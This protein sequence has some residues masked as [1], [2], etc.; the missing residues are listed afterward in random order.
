MYRSLGISKKTFE[1]RINLLNHV[2]SLKDHARS[3]LG[4]RLK[5]TASIGGIQSDVKNYM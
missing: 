3:L 1:V 5:F 4:S 2:S